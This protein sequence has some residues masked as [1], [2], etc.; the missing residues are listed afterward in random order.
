MD[1]PVTLIFWCFSMPLLAAQIVLA[2]H[3]LRGGRILWAVF[4]ILMP[5]FGTLAYYFARYRPDARARRL[6]EDAAPME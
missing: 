6:V 3:A 2:L 1:W 4:I 5:L